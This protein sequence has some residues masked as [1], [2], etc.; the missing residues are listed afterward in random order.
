MEDEILTVEEVAERFHV[1][2]Q[3]I[4][5]GWIASGKL[6]AGRIGRRYAIRAS[7][8]EAMLDEAFSERET[9]NKD[10]FGDPGER[11]GRAPHSDTPEDV[12]NS[13]DAGGQLIDGTQD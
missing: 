10:L 11:L 13:D 9:P 8:V 1:S 5:E 7:D 6:K 3:T 4:R 12:W 2:R